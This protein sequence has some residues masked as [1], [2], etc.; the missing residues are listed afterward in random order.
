MLS[1][2]LASS[3]RNGAAVLAEA[4]AEDDDLGRKSN[5]ADVLPRISLDASASENAKASGTLQK[6]SSVSRRLLDDPNSLFW[7]KSGIIF[8]PPIRYS[9]DLATQTGINQERTLKEDTLLCKRTVSAC[10]GADQPVRYKASREARYNALKEGWRQQK[11]VL[12]SEYLAIYSSPVSF[13]KI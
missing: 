6:K 13:L 1:N 9:T 4:D 3:S 7:R 2:A 10:G 11:V 8:L 12:T 5:H